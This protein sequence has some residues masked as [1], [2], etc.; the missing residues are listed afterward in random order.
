MRNPAQARIIV[1]TLG[2]GG[3]LLRC[4]EGI[5]ESRMKVAC[6]TVVVVDSPDGAGVAAALRDRPVEVR[7]TGGLGSAAAA[8][9]CG[10]KGFA[11]QFL[12][13][14]DAD[15]EIEPE[16]LER[17]LEP[18][19]EG[20]AEATVGNY[21]R[22]VTGLN[23]ASAYKQLYVAG[24]YARRCPGIRNDYWTAIAA[25]RADA[26]FALRGFDAR[27]K[28]ACGEDAEFGIRMTRAGLK[29]LA[30][31]DACGRHL[32]ALTLRSLV[33]NDWRKGRVAMRNHFLSDGPLAD[34]RH[35]S[36]RDMLGAVLASALA[37]CVTL[38]PA[39]PLS[40]ALL[41]AALLA[42]AYVLARLDLAQAFAAR[43]PAFLSG[44]LLTMIVLD[45]VRVACAA[46]GM[47]THRL[48][49]LGRAAVPAAAARPDLRPLNRG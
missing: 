8:R 36:R 24:V 46:L 22:D 10:A 5:G 6:E 28:G 1:P 23:F 12:I 18:L 31:T 39:L 21:S 37:A 35:A 14:I 34:N 15:V 13:F 41:V 19:R 48:E 16:C 9:N 42:G 40:N 43:G 4:L 27:Y 7:S 44:A 20:R 25:V 3:L 2:A 45:L 30:V 47:L 32:K 38:L 33:A 11:G 49:A 17:L 29:T 26:F